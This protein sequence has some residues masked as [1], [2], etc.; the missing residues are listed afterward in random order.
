MKPAKRDILVN[1]IGNTA[2]WTLV[3]NL[4]HQPS[5]H[6]FKI[7]EYYRQPECR[8][9][10]DPDD[11]VHGLGGGK[12]IKESYAGNGRQ[13]FIRHYHPEAQGN[14]QFMRACYGVA[15]L[16]DPMLSLLTLV[17]RVQTVDPVT[18]L[19]RRVDY[20]EPF[21]EMWKVEPFDCVP[22]D[23]PE[24]R[25]AL[26]KVF[27]ERAELEYKPGD[28][29]FTNT[30]GRSKPRTAY[31]ARDIPA[32]LAADSRLVEPYNALRSKAEA[33]R[34]F[35]ETHGYQNLPWWK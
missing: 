4:A 24:T 16:R 25:E 8:T 20:W 5:I 7:F 31:E 26:W 2:T 35:L 13:M 30:S 22:I 17:H 33:L 28:W 11:K 9:D 23:V 14:Y 1:S 32:M 29:I 6:G 34:P 3:W 21:V 27:L 15:P 18:T 12:F 19:A 10:N